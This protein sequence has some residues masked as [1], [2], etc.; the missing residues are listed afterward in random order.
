MAIPLMLKIG[1]KAEQQAFARKGPDYV[2]DKYL[3]E[4]LTEMGVI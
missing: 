2:T 3:P 4:R 1:K